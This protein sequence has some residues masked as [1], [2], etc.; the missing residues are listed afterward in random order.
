[1][2]SRIDAFFSAVRRSTLLIVSFSLLI[3]VGAFDLLTGA[4]LSI[5]LF[6]LAPILG[7]TWY[8]G[9]QEG[10]L[11]SLLGSLVW[12]AA[13]YGAGAHYAHPLIP[14]WNC[15]IRLGFFL[16]SVNLLHVMK[17]KLLLEEQYADT[18]SLTGLANSR[19]FY[20]ILQSEALR[21][22]R[23]GRP[24]T[25]VYIDLDDFKPVNDKLGHAAGDGV[26]RE[27]AGL[28]RSGTRATDT[29]ARLGG[30][31]F[32]GLFP[33]TGFESAEALI[34]NLREQLS[35]GVEKRGWPITFSIG[36]VTYPE[37]LEDLPGMV[38]AADDLM[39]RVKR[40]GKNGALHQLRG[41]E[42][43]AA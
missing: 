17:E 13:D 35:R 12:I 9:R 21:S 11:A 7:L 34:G 4:E 18:D 37:P 40:R 6:Y 22:K 36:A 42:P 8:A 32:V 26:L 3:L 5:S 33:E 41:N 10:L 19:K 29:I 39:Y 30:D 31:E 15:A 25:I 20:E 24:F 1:M 28:V 43:E 16:V 27:V 23:Y 38:K 14:W 2:L